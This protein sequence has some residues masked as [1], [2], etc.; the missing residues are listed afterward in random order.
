MKLFIVAVGSMY[1]YSLVSVIQV[2]RILKISNWFEKIVIYFTCYE[3]MIV[4][5]TYSHRYERV[6]GIVG[7]CLSAPRSSFFLLQL[8]KRKP[9]QSCDVKLLKCIFDKETLSDVLPAKGKVVTNQFSDFG[10]TVPLIEMS[11]TLFFKRLADLRGLSW[12]SK[13]CVKRIRF[14]PMMRD[15]FCSWV[16][17]WRSVSRRVCLQTAALWKRIA[18]LTVDVK[19]GTHLPFALDLSKN[20]SGW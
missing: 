20:F 9:Q 6:L 11:C 19:Q 12:Y 17:I 7:F 5:Q 1:K 18:Q 15:G 8:F 13:A 14:V 4:N 10:W 3:V 16:W 2:S